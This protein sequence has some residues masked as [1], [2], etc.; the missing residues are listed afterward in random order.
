[1]R[2]F[3][4]DDVIY[5]SRGAETLYGWTAAE[6]FGQITHS[7]LGTRFPVSREAV[8]EVLNVSGQWSGEL[9]HNRRDGGQVVVA[10][11]QV[12]HRDELGRPVATLEIN[13]DIT[14]QKRTEEERR[15]S[16][17]RF[18]LLV[19]NVRDYAIYLVSPD[20][21]VMSW[22]EGAERLKG[23]APREIIG[24]PIARFY[25]PEDVVSGLPERLLRQAVEQ[26]WVEHEGW[27]IRKDG[28]RFWADVVITALRDEQN[29]LRGFAKVTRDLTERRAVEEARAL[30]SREEGARAASE[31]G[32]AQLRASRDQL[33][34]TL[35]GVS[36]GITARDASGRMVVANDAAARLCGFSSA[37]ELLAASP[38]EILARF[39][40]LDEHGAAL[41]RER[42]PGQEVLAG[43]PQAER[44]IRFRVK[45]TGEEHWS[46][47]NA[48]PIRD[49][50]GRV[51]MEV[52]VFRDV[53][54]QK[55]AE[56]AARY[57][58]AVNL[59]LARSLDYEQTLTRIAELAVPTLADWCVIDVLDAGDTL[60]RLAI[61]HVDPAKK[62]LAE[63]LSRRYP[64]DPRSPT[65]AA[66]VVR[67]GVAEMYSEITDAQ[68]QAG[69]RDA[70]HL[71]LIRA[72]QLHSIIV[73]PLRARGRTLGTIMVV[74]AESGRRYGQPDLALVEDLALRAALALD[75]ARLYR[76]SQEQT[77]VHV[78]LNAALR[79]A[80]ARLEQ[81]MQT[82]EEF[83]A[84]ASHDLKGPIASIKAMSQLLLRRVSRSGGLDTDQLQQSL[85]RIDLVA[86]RAANQVDELL[87][88]T[89]LQM[90]HPI[91]LDRREVDVGLLVSEV[92]AEYRQ[93]SERHVINLEVDAGIVGSL[94]QQRVAR[95][96]ANLIENAIKY[97]PAGGMVRIRVFRGS[98][99]P[100]GVL[101]VQD[102]GIGIPQED[103]GRIFDRFHRGSNVL[104]EIP[105]TGIG[106]ASARHI[107]ESHG[108]RIS[109]E[110]RPGAG[111][112]F[113]VRF[114]LG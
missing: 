45:A 4:T 27:R 18:R 97:S 76:E 63:E 49:A 6:A 44:L 53:T 31:A 10:S 50:A 42:L 22:N 65:G 55:R 102:D 1:V 7:L 48:T 95:V 33:A 93:Q 20:G 41:P 80:M 60:R 36:E 56:D 113:T 40:I 14:E 15:E 83:L 75:N 25:P 107:V 91:E 24:Q 70:E 114:P 99:A 71:S 38:E 109:V 11:R 101:T 52:S 34:A 81:A 105:G 3:G 112:T 62:R 51:T 82:R 28:S 16:E 84:A 30:A 106:L 47:V 12:V 90:G 103:L 26:G 68:L 72:L 54:D 37:E 104:G 2:T 5:W 32:Q 21:Q 35:E 8:D 78:E 23:Y 111:T 92:V 79:D 29:R 9:L 73:A 39:D 96:V 61:V 77:A 58:S 64:D 43:R 86:T 98:D 67:T 94:D 89:R 100:D 108:G 85:S 59:E 87:D 17:E 46:I 69:A 57:M 13:T 19:A 74:A 110:S 88:I 66:H